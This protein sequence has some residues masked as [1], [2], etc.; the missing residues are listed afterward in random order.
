MPDPGQ[1]TRYE[2]TLRSGV[3]ISLCDAWD[4]TAAFWHF[5]SP[6]LL[7]SPEDAPDW[8]PH[9]GSMLPSGFDLPKRDKPISP[10][11]R[12]RAALERSPDL[13]RLVDL[14]KREPGGRAAL[15]CAIAGYLGRAFREPG[16]S[17]GV[18]RLT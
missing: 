18:A 5:A 3:G 8:A 11:D 1:L 6:G 10:F 15:E 4:P 16:G 12:M 7:P 9:G 17:E 2:L 14:A 13:A